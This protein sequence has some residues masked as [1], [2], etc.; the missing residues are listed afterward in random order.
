LLAVLLSGCAALVRD[1]KQRLIRVHAAATSAEI[2]ITLDNTFIEAYKDRVTIDVSMT[3]DKADTRPHP[4]LVDGDFH[5]AGSSPEIGLPFVAEIQNAA[6][7]KEATDLV[8]GIAGIGRPLA[9][10]GVWRIWSEH[11]GESEETQG[12]EIAE[13]ESTNP[14]HVFEIHPVTRA[15]ELDLLRSLHPVKGY[16]PGSADLVFRTFEKI[17]CRISPGAAMTTVVTPKKQFND[18]E[19]LLEAGREP[20]QAVSDGRFVVGAVLD[21]KG[22]VLVPRVRMVFVKDSP[23]EK[24]VQALPPGGHLHVFGLPRINLA[25]VASRVARS[26]DEPGLLTPGLPYEIVIVGVYEDGK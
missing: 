20:Q 21:L 16:R 19:F 7:E 6:K 17:P 22:N 18:A 14:D 4:A 3:V 25:D 12:K 1:T 13:S 24:I 23:P 9:V 10:A 15:A 8:R 26:G 2:A 11:V 5:I